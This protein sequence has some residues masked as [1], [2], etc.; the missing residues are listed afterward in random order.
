MSAVFIAF[1]CAEP[2]LNVSM[3][4][5]PLYFMCK[6][7]V[8]SQLNLVCICLLIHAHRLIFGVFTV[9]YVDTNTAARDLLCYVD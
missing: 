9:I 4:P 6:L 7:V 5:F 1:I 8:W 2:V 3:W